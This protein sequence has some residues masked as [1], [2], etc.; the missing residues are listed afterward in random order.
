MHVY[1]L[2]I[3]HTQ[4]LRTMTVSAYNIG[5]FNSSLCCTYTYVHNIITCIVFASL[6]FKRVEES[7][8]MWL[9]FR[10]GTRTNMF[11]LILPSSLLSIGLPMLST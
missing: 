3:A 2:Y 9:S 6:T 1:T 11:A 10:P 5:H 4:S 8:I 7:W